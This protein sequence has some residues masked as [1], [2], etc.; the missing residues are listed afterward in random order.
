MG[1]EAMAQ[2][3]GAL[4]GASLPPVFEGVRFSRPVHILDGASV[5]VRLAALARSPGVV[6]V[7]L[8]SSETAF[9]ID[10]FRAV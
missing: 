9:Q 4:C 2:V 5:T 8:R 7:V 1:L 6:E 3:A 10:H